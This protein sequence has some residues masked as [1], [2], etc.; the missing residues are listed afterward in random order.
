MQL[1]WQYKT[2]LSF[3][4]KTVLVM[5]IENSGGD[6]AVE[7]GRIAKQVYLSTRRGTWVFNRVGSNGIPLD[8]TMKTP[9]YSLASKY[10][11]WLANLVMERQM[12]SIDSSLNIEHL[13]S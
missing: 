3:E 7:L 9:L 6:M 13:S 11:P 12:N 5:G 8:M 1:C 10:C 2:P 4:N